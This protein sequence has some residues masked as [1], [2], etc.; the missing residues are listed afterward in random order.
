MYNYSKSFLEKAAVETG[1]VRDNL[2]KVFRL[3]DILQLTR[4]IV[5]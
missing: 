3:C 2:E 5:R 4:Y 1:F